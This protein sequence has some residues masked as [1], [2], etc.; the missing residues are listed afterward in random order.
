MDMEKELEV[1]VKF[2]IGDPSE[3]AGKL[4]KIG[5]R[6]IDSGLER[7]IKYGG[8]GIDDTED[9]L[10]LRSYAG[11]ADITHKRKPENAPKGFKVMQETIVMIDSFER[12]KKLLEALGYRPV[13]VYEKKRQTWELGKVGILVDVMPLIGNF[14]EIEGSEDEIVATAGKLG[15][16]MRDAIAKSYG[17]LF[18]KYCKVKGVAKDAFTFGD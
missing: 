3:I 14:I 18:D 17:D 4:R 8:H 2:R 13:F 10:R 9:L 15:L 16:D 11:R 7:N 1:E 12:G 5:A 6:M